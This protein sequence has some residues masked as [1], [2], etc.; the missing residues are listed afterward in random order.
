MSS[1]INE[2]NKYIV[3]LRIERD[4]L[5][6]DFIKL[7]EEKKDIEGIN[8]NLIRENLLLNQ[9]N[10]EILESNNDLKLENTIY[11]IATGLIILATIIRFVINSGIV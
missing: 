7:N 5:M 9:E 2:L 6:S 11:R 10:V 8:N 4:N 3:E 1:K